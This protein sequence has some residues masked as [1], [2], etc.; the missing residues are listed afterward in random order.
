MNVLSEVFFMSWGKLL[1]IFL[2][3]FFRYNYI[4]VLITLGLKT[5]KSLL[6][7]G[8]IRKAHKVQSL[9]Q[10]FDGEICWRLQSNSSLLLASF[11]PPILT[12]TEFVLDF[13]EAAK[14]NIS[15][16]VKHGEL[17]SHCVWAGTEYFRGI[18]NSFANREA[19]A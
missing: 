7:L 11:L 17:N 3:P 13:I 16:H 6:W 14:Q 10:V 9:D 8:T 15:S 12:F 5:V 1:K 4:L 19:S 2:H 18:L